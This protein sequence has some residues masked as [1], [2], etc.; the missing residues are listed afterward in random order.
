[1]SEPRTIQLPAKSREKVIKVASEMN[2]YDNQLNHVLV[3]AG[4]AMGLTGKMV[5]S[6]DLTTITTYT[7]EGEVTATANITP[8]IKARVEAIQANI[9][10]TNANF[11]NIMELLLDANGYEDMSQWVITA[12]YSYLVHRED[13][14]AFNAAASNEVDTVVEALEEVEKLSDQ[15]LTEELVEEVENVVAEVENAIDEVKV[16][17]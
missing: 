13:L 5:V 17:V 2:V 12:D 11:S 15:E 10:T 4:E 8:A 7:D 14:E 3:I 6:E 9:A 1:M 16:S